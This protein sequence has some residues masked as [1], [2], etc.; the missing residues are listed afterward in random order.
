MIGRMAEEQGLGLESLRRR[1]GELGLP[2]PRYTWD[3]PYLVL[4]LYRSTEA[5]TRQLAD[6]IVVRL[7]VDAKMAWQFVVTREV[8]TSRELMDELHFDERKAQRVLK[9]LIENNLVHRIGK[10]PATRYKVI[11]E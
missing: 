3:N 5:A 2:L 7:N 9:S 10:G 11:R 8:V 1:A 4:T 6:S